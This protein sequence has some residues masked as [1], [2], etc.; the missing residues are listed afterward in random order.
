MPAKSIGAGRPTKRQ[1]EILEFVMDF[2]RVN[3][4]SPSLGEIARHFGISI[5]TVHQHVAYLRKKGLLKKKKGEK[6]SIEVLNDRKRDVVEIPLMGIIAAGGP[7]EAI[8]NPEP[9]EVPRTMLPR[10]GNYF[11]LRVAGTSMIEEGIADGDV[12]IV[13]EQQTVNPGETAVAYLPDKNEVTLKKVYPE[14]NRVRLV[15]ANRSMKPFYETNVEV[16]GRVVGVLR[17][18]F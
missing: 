7:I 15:P 8:A 6:R 17:H 11:A 14:R 5:P 3:P 18:A 13:R 2:Q 10:G 12:V 16:Q 4:Y 1:A 9:I